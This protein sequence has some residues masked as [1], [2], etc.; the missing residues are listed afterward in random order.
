MGECEFQHREKSFIYCNFWRSG[1]VWITKR[2]VLKKELPK[3]LV[4]FWLRRNQHGEKTDPKSRN[5]LSFGKLLKISTSSFVNLILWRC[6]ESRKHPGNWKKARDIQKVKHLHSSKKLFLRIFE[7][8]TTHPTYMYKFK[9]NE[10]YK[11]FFWTSHPFLHYVYV[12]GI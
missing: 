10:V 12:L 2:G 7:F 11:T 6:N 3:W 9:Y 1:N 4:L 5:K 8:I